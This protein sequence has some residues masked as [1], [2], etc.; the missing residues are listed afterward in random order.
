MARLVEDTAGKTR[1]RPIDPALRKLLVK[2]AGTAGVDLVRVTSGGQ[3]KKGTPGK[4]TGSTRHD[5]GMA[6]DLQLVIAGKTLDFTTATDRKII[7]K[8][9]EA[10]AAGGATG[11][12][13]GVDYMGPRTLHVGFGSKSIWGAGG[14]A[15]KAPQWLK[16]AVNKGWS[17][18]GTDPEPAPAPAPAPSDGTLPARYV[19]MARSGLKLRAGPGTTFGSDT[20]LATGTT[21][22]VLAFEGD[23]GGWAKVDLEGDGLVDGFLFASFLAP[24]TLGEPADDG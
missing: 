8:F 12:G 6:A 2:A 1:D 14:K 19:V 9:I 23:D 22:T 24:V 21:V 7:E 3:A 11:L 4:R 17:R 15:A 5:L 10:A 13:A 20:A 18:A 16:D